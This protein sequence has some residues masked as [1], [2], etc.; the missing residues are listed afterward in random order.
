[1]SGSEDGGKLA[2]GDAAAV[3]EGCEEVL[4]HGAALGPPWLGVNITRVK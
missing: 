1:M 3:V 4:G 2:R